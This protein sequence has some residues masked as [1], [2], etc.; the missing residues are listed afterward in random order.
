[1][2][3]SS[4]LDAVVL[5][6]RACDH[7]VNDLM[8]QIQMSVALDLPSF[9]VKEEIILTQSGNIHTYIAIVERKRVLSLLDYLAPREQPEDP[10]YLKRKDINEPDYMAALSQARLTE[11][12]Q[13]RYSIEKVS[14][15]AM[16]AISLLQRLKQIGL[17]LGDV[18]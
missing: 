14:Y 16:Q 17:Y 10:V 1:M 12:L 3:E 4:L 2:F 18:G 15:F 6:G 9:R 13:S 5:L 11:R 8:W 7:H